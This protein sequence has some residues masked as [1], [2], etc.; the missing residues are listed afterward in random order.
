MSEQ[1]KIDDG[2]SAFPFGTRAIHYDPCG[3]GRDVVEYIQLPGMSLRDYFAA[4]AD[5]PGYVE[6]YQLAG[7][8]EVACP[9]GFNKDHF[10][11][12]MESRARVWWGTISVLEKY[13]FYSRLRFLA[14]DAML[15]EKKRRSAPSGDTAP[16]PTP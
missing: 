13:R 11:T 2:G 3:G 16:K 12:D 8:P 15:A 6:A 1:N 10:A 9:P 14:A 5:Q 7:C 4:H